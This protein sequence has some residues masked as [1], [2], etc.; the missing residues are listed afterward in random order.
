MEA[1][2]A[3]AMV[4]KMFE[5]GKITLVDPDTKYRYSLTAK[6]PDDGEYADVARFDKAG[7]TLSRVVFKCVQCEE[8]FEVRQ[9]QMMVI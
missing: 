2:K 3:P 1:K 9:D 5:T 6:C 7:N 8:E 4:K